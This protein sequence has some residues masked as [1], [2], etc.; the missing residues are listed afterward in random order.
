MYMNIGVNAW[1]EIKHLSHSKLSPGEGCKLWRGNYIMHRVC[2]EMKAC[3]LQNCKR[4]KL[5]KQR[6]GS[7]EARGE[8]G[9]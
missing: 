7:I 2:F 6:Y 3:K 4:L 8:V 1:N 9:G 5:N